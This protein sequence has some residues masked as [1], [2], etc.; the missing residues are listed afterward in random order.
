M[1][2]EAWK[3]FQYGRK[4]VDLRLGDMEHLPLSDGE[5]DCAV[6]SMV[7]H[8]LSRPEVAIA[9]ACRVLKPE[10]SLI[11]ADFARHG[12]EAM[13][14]TYNDRWLGFSSHDISRWLSHNGFTLTLSDAYKI[15]HSMEIM[16]FKANKKGE[17]EWPV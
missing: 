13:R 8:H 5:A 9:E 6:I 10:G 16:I 11:I 7:L 1:L 15:K 2:D 14:H 17:K 12:N 4:R 3:R